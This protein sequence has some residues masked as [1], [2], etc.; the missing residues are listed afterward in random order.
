MTPVVPVAKITVIPA[1]IGIA[2]MSRQTPMAASPNPMLVAPSP[3]STDPDV[4]RHGTRRDALHDGCRHR[5]RHND[6]SRSH[7]H[8][9]RGCYHRHRNWDSEADADVNTSVYSGDSQ[10]CQSQ[11]CD[12]LFHIVCWLDA[13]TGRGRV[14]NRLRF[15]NQGKCGCRPWMNTDSPRGAGPQ[16]MDVAEPSSI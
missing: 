1:V 16:Q 12:C 5:R 14:I 4:P 6:R 15:C 2:P 11:N 7:Y 8:R 3:A 10:S 9:D 13:P